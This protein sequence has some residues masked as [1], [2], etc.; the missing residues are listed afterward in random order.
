M[1]IQVNGDNRDIEEGSTVSDLLGALKLRADQ[2]AVEIN[3]KIL[4]RKEFDG[5][6]LQE[7]DRIEILSF[8]GGG[9]PSKSQPTISR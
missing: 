1:H 2:V 4:D 3:L 8:I 9:T 5:M 6:V 7:D